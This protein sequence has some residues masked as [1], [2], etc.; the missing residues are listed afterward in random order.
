MPEAQRSAL[1]AQRC[2]PAF[3]LP[4]LTLST[5]CPSTLRIVSATS[6]LRGSVKERV[7]VGLKG[8]G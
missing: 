6:A 4:M 2:S 5:T 8:L 1:T 7:V 3:I